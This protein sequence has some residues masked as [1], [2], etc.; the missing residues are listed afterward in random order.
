MRPDRLRQFAWGA[1]GD[2]PAV[3]HD[4]VLTA[5]NAITLLRLLGL[6]LFVWLL[7]AREAAAAA[8][9]VLVVVAATDWVDG[10]VARRFDQVSRLGQVLDPLIDRVLL[11][12]VALT[13]LAAGIVQWWLVAL[14]V[15]RDLVLLVGA[16]AVFRA[17]PPIPVTR[18]GKTATA[19]LLGALPGFLLAEAGWAAMRELRTGSWVLAGVGVVAY[20]VAA[21]QYTRAALALRSSRP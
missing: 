13:L 8:F 9:G 19:C 17:I 5:A 18:V 3:V 4:R 21:G 12:T 6:P 14:V 2:G 16:A 20:Y 7:L 10:Y 11:A 15:G 1:R